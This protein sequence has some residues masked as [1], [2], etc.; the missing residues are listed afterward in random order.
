ME[1]TERRLLLKN[2]SQQIFYWLC[3]II[4]SKRFFRRAGL[5]SCYVRPQWFC[6]LL[7]T[8]LQGIFK[9]IETLPHRQR[10][11]QSL[12][13]SASQ[14]YY[15]ERRSRTLS[16]SSSASIWAFF[17]R[18]SITSESLKLKN[19]GCWKRTNSTKSSTKCRE[20]RTLQFAGE[21]YQQHQIWPQPCMY[22]LQEALEGEL[23]MAKLLHRLACLCVRD[24][25]F[26]DRTSLQ[27]DISLPVFTN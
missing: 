8:S 6:I 20:V 9:Q 19:M 22:N 18:L 13:V 27:I 17:Q 25:F 5:W 23:R 1:F 21:T 3:A 12:K 26:S 2:I 7:N 15:Q 24:S 16:C 4:L 14:T 11:F 10:F